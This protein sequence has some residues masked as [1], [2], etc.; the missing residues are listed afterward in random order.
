MSKKYKPSIFLNN[1][2]QLSRQD[3]LEI[4]GIGEVL[5]K[6][7][8]EFTS[9]KR[10]EKLIFEFEKLEKNTEFWIE[11]STQ[12]NLN[13]EKNVNE[14][15]Q[16]LSQ[17]TICITG[18]FEISR[19]EIKEKLENLG[20]KVVDSLSSKTT[21]LLAGQKSGSKLSKAK[22]MKIKIETELSKIFN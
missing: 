10:L 15:S 5:A 21:I 2:K 22:T 12:F 13:L 9:S 7:I 1:L 6:N 8:S 14:N 11:S 3:L 17:E 19:S 4:K 18:I 20:A 16:K